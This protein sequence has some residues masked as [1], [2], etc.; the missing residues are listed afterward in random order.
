MSAAEDNPGE[1]EA[2]ADAGEESP[3][4]EEMRAAVEEQLRKVRVEDLL[5]ES[6]AGIV[7]LTARRIAKEDERDL[8]Q[9][10]L[11]IEAVRALVPLLPEEA[12]GQIRNALSQLQVLFAQ[13]TEGGG[14]P[15]PQAPGEGSPEQTSGGPSPSQAPPGQAPGPAGPV[16]RGAEP[17]PRLWTPRGSE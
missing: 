8:D 7:N 17:P 12:A 13:A 6:V 4:E 3:S 10:R 5:L 11:G 16:K 2:T 1:A 9:A 14:A 15:G